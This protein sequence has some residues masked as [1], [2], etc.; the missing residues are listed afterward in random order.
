MIMIC[1]QIRNLS[2]VF[3]LPPHLV[4]CPL[5]TFGHWALAFVYYQIILYYFPLLFG[6]DRPLTAF[7]RL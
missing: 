7:D 6:F 3:P 5:A 4:P 1:S 2:V